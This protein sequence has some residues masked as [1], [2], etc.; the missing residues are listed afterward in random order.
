MASLTELTLYTAILSLAYLQRLGSRWI[1]TAILSLAYLQR[2]GSS[3]IN[4]AI[5]SFV[6]LRCSELRFI[7]RMTC[8]LV[9]CEFVGLGGKI[10][11]LGLV[12]E[13]GVP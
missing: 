1:Y 5:P 11:I 12:E 7:E 10:G 2:L 4:A 6:Y 3:Q 9:G 8:G 13:V